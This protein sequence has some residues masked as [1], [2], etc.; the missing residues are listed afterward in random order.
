M[1]MPFLRSFVV[2]SINPETIA[3]V[4]EAAGHLSTGCIVHNDVRSAFEAVSNEPN[5]VL[6]LDQSLPDFSSVDAYLSGRETPVRAPVV[7]LAEID[8]RADILEMV[9]RYRL[10]YMIL[11]GLL[12]ATMADILR[13]IVERHDALM[14]DASEGVEA[15]LAL[16]ESETKYRDL[17]EQSPDAILI[18]QDGVF[19]FLNAAALKLF[20]ASHPSQLLGTPVL[21]RVQP[22]YRETVRA[23]MNRILEHGAIA[24]L[25]EQVYLRLDGKPVDVEAV[26]MPFVH[27]GRAAVQ[28]L[29]RSI[30]ERKTFERALQK[31]D[32]RLQRLLEITRYKAVSSDDL[33]R[34]GLRQSLE[35]MDSEI[36][37]LRYRPLDDA[38]IRS[39]VFV[40]DQTGSMEF[41]G[42]L[43]E[44]CGV[45]ESLWT[46]A[47]ESGGSHHCRNSATPGVG[48]CAVSARITTI[49]QVLSV[50][51]TVD[52]DVHAV[53][54]VSRKT[55]PYSSTNVKQFQLMA[56]GLWNAYHSWE[57]EAERRQL[58]MAVEQ[59]PV[60][61][62]ITNNA[63]DI[64][65]ANAALTHIS[66][67]ALED[68]LGRNP[69]MF[70]SGLTPPEVYEDLWETIHAGH[71]WRGEFHNRKKD[72]TLYWEEARI[73]PLTDQAG[74][75]IGFVAVKTDITEHKELI[76]ELTLEKERAEESD[77]LKS[78]FLAN[79]SHE[80]RTP[81][82]IILGFTELMREE[83]EQ[84]NLR[85]MAEFVHNGS[86]R[87]MDTLNLILEL[88]RME[89]G[90][91]SVGRD[92]FMPASVLE[93]VLGP[94][95]AKA[96]E[97]GLQFA[98]HLPPDE[99]HF[100]SD[101][102]LVR[103]MLHNLVD[104]AI[105]FTDRG[106]VTVELQW[107]TDAGF[108]GCE[109]RVTDTGIGIS[110]EQKAV[111]FEPFRQASEGYTRKF[112]GAGL[113]LSL[114][115]KYCELLGGW[116]EVQSTPGAGSMFT[117]FLPSLGMDAPSSTAQGSAMAV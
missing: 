27:E 24:A 10:E 88:S 100:A 102:F 39:L 104:N 13:H 1:R 33:L 41:I 59:S 28:I 96:A 78:I 106:S 74:N 54:G 36:A 19:V 3:T 52:N 29:A 37:F 117:V 20:D 12:P 57:T 47:W 17:V 70:Q 25:N 60:S 46:N 114:C 72:G 2:A 43:D 64:G 50:P 4:R 103:E 89:S 6:L 112:D 107:R 99:R 35:L 81:M 65:F 92:Y 94:Y 75:G 44:Q 110:A 86:M 11:E 61:I 95:A 109:L 73:A 101:E 68:V 31:N 98:F 69:R 30:T 80:L 32:E 23:R 71:P 84:E 76:T 48:N 82:N 14:L 38:A 93:Q 62:F 9:V 97:K 111:I 16:Q 79:M 115:R 58:L 83:T 113:G 40:R 85:E 108:D 34:F 49:S 53:L 90:A 18:H 63:G 67:Y 56:D 45:C 87:L 26:G 116:L 15:R 51:V 77:R 55:A 21:D 42:G 8:T 105:K 91:V 22:Q 7:I 66:G 5:S